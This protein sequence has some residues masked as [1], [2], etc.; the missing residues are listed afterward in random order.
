MQD[1]DKTKSELLK[2]PKGLR[3]RIDNLETPKIGHERTEKVIQTA[4]RFLIIANSHTE[5]E[6]LLQEFA[7]ELKKFT[8]CAAVAIRILD[9]GGNI[10]Y[11]AYKGFSQR[12]YESESALSIKAD[13]CMCINVINGTTNP[14]LPFYTPGGSFY[15]NGTTRFLTTVSEEEKGTTRN[16]CNQFGY[17]S[18]ALVPISLGDRILGLIHVADTQENKVPFELVQIL[19]G[20]AMQLG[21]AIQRVWAEDMLKKAYDSLEQRVEER[22]AELVAVNK[23]LKQEIKDRKQKEKALRES[24]NRLRSLSSQLLSVQ[25]SERRRVARE[26]HDGIGQMLTAVKFKVESVLQEKGEGK[27]RAMEKSLEDVIPMIRESMEEVRRIQMD[28]R[29][30]VLDDLGILAALTWLCRNFEATYSHIHIE[31]QTEIREEEVSTPLKTPIYRIA[32]EALNNVAKHSKADLAHVS[33]RK[34]NG[35]I[36]LVINDNGAGFDLKSA[37]S[38]KSYKGGFGLSGMRERTELSGGSFEIESTKGVGT[39]IRALWPTE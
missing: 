8:E 14:K 20:V 3:Q 5:M 7:M 2:K 37:P 9:E 21:T 33:L 26:L 29:P 1:A 19:E 31:K 11:K 27:A 25:E 23:Q 13:Q 6:P 35:K 30:S 32:Q 39:L 36:E 28:L 10:P 24:E 38:V 16:V 22:T 12:F 18:V 15:M 34:T 4:H 17:E